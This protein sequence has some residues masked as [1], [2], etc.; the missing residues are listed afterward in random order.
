LPKGVN[1]NDYMRTALKEIREFKVIA[2]AENAEINA[3]WQALEDA[4][5]DQFINDSTEHGVKRWESIL[6]ITPKGSDTLDFRKFRI[7][8]RL[9][10]QLPYSYRAVEQQL[11]TLC[12]EDGYSLELQNS[13]YTLRVRVALTAK[14]N[15]DDVG[16]L[17]KRV[18]PA[19]IV[20][21]LSLLYNQHSM[22]SK[23]TH[24]QLSKYTHTQLRNEVL[25]Q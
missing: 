12:G 1:I 2:N 25:I 18:V 10:E 20:I 9:N 13:K 3:L 8:T 15:Y 24:E 14:S 7:I 6:N 16:T 19:N 11:K 5:N 22:L 17:L 4:L 23:Y 21:D